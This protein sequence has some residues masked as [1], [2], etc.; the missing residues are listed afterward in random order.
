MIVVRRVCYY[1]LRLRNYLEG[2][3][4]RGCFYYSYSI[5]LGYL[6][7]LVFYYDDIIYCLGKG[8]LLV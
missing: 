4:G 1:N 6:L 3:Y 8:L 5:K 7:I 2:G